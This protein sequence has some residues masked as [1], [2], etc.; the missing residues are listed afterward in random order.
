MMDLVKITWTDTE[1]FKGS[2]WASKEEV[3][4]FSNKLCTIESVGWVVKKTRHYLT[5]CSDFSPNPDT[6]GR[7]TKITR[8]M[9]VSVEAL[10]L[11]PM[12]ASVSESQTVAPVR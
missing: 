12:P 3:D 10:Q 7:V 9:I 2:S 8:K 11:V 6:H 1:D 5:I 4:E